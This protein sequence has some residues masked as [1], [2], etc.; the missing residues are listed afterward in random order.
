MAEKQTLHS[1]A[2]TV[3]AE[4]VLFEQGTGGGGMVILL[5]GRLG[6]YQNGY[7]VGEIS[8]PG[9]YVGEASVLTGAERTATVKTETSST[10]VRL[11]EKQALAFLKKS[12][13]AEAKAVRSISERLQDANSRMADKDERLVAQR[14]AMGELLEGLRALYLRL[15]SV[16]GAEDAR[17]ALR[18]LI[19]KYGT[20]RFSKS[21]VQV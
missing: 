5:A 20:G 2:R 3:P 11:S 18:L 21:R 1:L 13:A 19:N 4:T 15:D 12:E 14:E 17:K 8:E 6:V 10:I 16:R 9:A 7:R